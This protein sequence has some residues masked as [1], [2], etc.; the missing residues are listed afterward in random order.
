LPG[1]HSN[2]SSPA[3]SLERWLQAFSTLQNSKMPLSPD[4]INTNIS[5][6]EFELLVKEYLEG[7]GKDLKTF[8]ATH[9]THL[10]NNDG[11]YQIDVYAEFDFLGATFKVLVECK[12]HKNRIKREVVQ[13]LYDKLRSAGAQKG[14]VFSTSG[15]QDGAKK[16]AIEHGIALV[17]VIEGRFTYFTKSQDSQ[18]FEPPPW[19]DIPKY[20]GEYQEGNTTCYLQNGYFDALKEFL[21]EKNN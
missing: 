1:G 20:V 14:M 6:R 5:P 3:A 4:D 7:V 12:R 8:T 21:F 19:A 16:Y 9:N 18:N 10:K 2:Y 15:F 17:K 13:L 11:E